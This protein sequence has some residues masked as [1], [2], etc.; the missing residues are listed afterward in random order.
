[1][2]VFLWCI[3]LLAAVARLLW[4]LFFRIKA[5]TSRFS[6]HSNENTLSPSI[7]I[8]VCAHNNCTGL[9]RLLPVLAS[10]DYPLFEI[11]V[12]NDRSTDQTADWLNQVSIS[13]LRV[14]TITATPD[15]WN[16]KKYA[17]TQGIQSTQYPLLA[18]TDSDCVP[19][20]S[21][22]LQHVA[23][24][25]TQPGIDIFLGYS[26]YKEQ[27]SILNRIIQTETLF[28]ALQYF[29][30]ANVGFTYM[31]VGRNLGYSKNFISKHLDAFPFYNH[32][33]GDDDLL[34]NQLSTGKDAATSTHPDSFV[35]TFPPEDFKSWWKQKRRHLSAGKLYK[36]FTK[37][38][39]GL[40]WLSASFFWFMFLVLLFLNT[41][42][43]NTCLILA[44][45]LFFGA[46]T[47]ILYPIFRI[48]K[49]GRLLPLFLFWDFL[50]IAS[51][52]IIGF[53]TFLVKNK[54]WS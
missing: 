53:S 21:R 23:Q 35:L 11:I 14:V 41:E 49:S 5:D 15:G 47:V 1:M 54:K 18:L 44:H 39:L 13:N 50:Y 29:S 51:S 34:I 36:P 8:V 31:G 43:A 45:L 9:Q 40:Y 16:P 28:T 42:K 10:Q 30:L 3:Y 4:W 27:P 37:S 2:I 52:S 46:G 17:L 22:W 19:Q 33:G 26:P 7:S 38:L 24:Q 25:L 32:L 12:V 6:S 20:S 48:F